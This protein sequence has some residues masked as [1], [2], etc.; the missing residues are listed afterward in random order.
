[1]K[2]CLCPHLFPASEKQLSWLSECHRFFFLFCQSI[3][4]PCRERQIFSFF[5]LPFY[6]FFF[7]SVSFFSTSV[8]TARLI[9]L[10]NVII[11]SLYV[12]VFPRAS[13]LL[14]LLLVRRSIVVI[15]RKVVLKQAVSV[16]PFD[17][18]N[19]LFF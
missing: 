13:V 16:F 19:I 3:I 1:M 11:F 10:I 9:I 6:L 5:L 17:I 18:G 12:D 8:Y 4:N 14:L 7:F 2:L 15:T